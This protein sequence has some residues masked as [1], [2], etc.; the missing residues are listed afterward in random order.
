M[1][2]KLET[3]LV[4]K[5]IIRTISGCAASLHGYRSPYRGI[6]L[7]DSA[8]EGVLQQLHLAATGR[9]RGCGTGSRT[10]AVFGT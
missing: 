10:Q 3:L 7:Q 9:S 8:L 2:D 4:D 6:K 1:D 5:Y